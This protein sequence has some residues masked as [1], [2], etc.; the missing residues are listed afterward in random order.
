MAFAF[1]AADN[2]LIG[3]LIK[4]LLGPGSNIALLTNFD[5]SF[6]ASES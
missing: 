3:G 2:S 4:E 5:K 1:L 6:S